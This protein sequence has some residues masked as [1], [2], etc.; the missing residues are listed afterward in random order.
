MQKMIDWKE[1]AKKVSIAT[2][3]AFRP[4]S[5][6]AVGGGCINQCFRL[7]DRQHDY[8]VKINDPALMP[9]FEAEL[10]G[11]ATISASATIRTPAPICAGKT[12]LHAYLV[13]EFIPLGGGG[14][15]GQ[16]LAGAQIA[17]MHRHLGGAYGGERDNF[18]GA[19]PQPNR[20][21]DDWTGFW[22]EQRL[23]F[24]LRLA[25]ERGYRGRLQQRGEM[26]LEAFPALI[27][28]APP[29]SLIHGDLWGGNLAFDREGRPVIFDPAAYYGDR[30]AEIAMTELFGGFGREFYAAYNEAWALDSGYAIRKRLYNLYH[31]LNHLNLFGGGYAGQ[32]LSL[33]DGLLAE[34]GH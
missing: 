15:N 27:D 4:D 25:A 1:I 24:Q 19:T 23:G 12:P 6:G 28:H 11:L 33:I 9:M 10:T 17:A 20:W 5:V 13:L 14:T 30:E 21:H 22:R 16:R 3:Q 32:S 29:P 2:G 34:L 7:G 18:I 31:I 26:L 8:F